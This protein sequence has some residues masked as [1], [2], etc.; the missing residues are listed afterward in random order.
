MP[1]RTTGVSFFRK[2][3]GRDGESLVRKH[4]KRR[5]YRILARNYTCP[6][7]EIDIICLDGQTIVFVEVKTRSSDA[8]A[9]PEETIT[10]AKQR[11]LARVARFWLETHGRPQCAYRFDA[12]GVVMPPGKTPI[13][14]HF[15]D[16]FVPAR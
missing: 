13:V 16:A 15:V 4:L 11:Q 12:V 14:S 3:L 5:G 1:G 9:G 6:V 8:D 2:I 7:G 10:R